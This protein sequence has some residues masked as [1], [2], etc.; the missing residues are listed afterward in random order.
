M[1][2][3]RADSILTNSD[4]FSNLEKREADKVQTL[5]LSLSLLKKH[6][7]TLLVPKAPKKPQKNTKN[8]DVTVFL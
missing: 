1:Q 6:S 3:K 7:F 4:Q 8:Q 2:S 5:Q